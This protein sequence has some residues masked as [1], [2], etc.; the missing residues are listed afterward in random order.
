MAEKLEQGYR[1]VSSAIDITVVTV[2]EAK[3]VTPLAKDVLR[4]WRAGHRPTF[5]Q[6]EEGELYKGE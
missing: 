3:T 4:T 1:N 2:R 5:S 6:Q